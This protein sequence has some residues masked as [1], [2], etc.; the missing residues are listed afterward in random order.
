MD[1]GSSCFV[2]ECGPHAGALIL[3]RCWPFQHGPESFKKKSYQDLGS[4]VYTLLTPEVK[5]PLQLPDHKN[6]D[7]VPNRLLRQ[8]SAVIAVVVLADACLHLITSC[9]YLHNKRRTV[10]VGNSVSLTY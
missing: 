1:G 10:N 6:G 9:S 4:L 8:S 7:I 5:D 3:D 2:P